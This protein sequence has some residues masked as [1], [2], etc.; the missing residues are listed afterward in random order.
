MGQLHSLSQGPISEK[1]WK[2]LIAQVPEMP[3]QEI[4]DQIKARLE[5]KNVGDWFGKITFT[6]AASVDDIGDKH[7]QFFVSWKLTTAPRAIDSGDPD[8]SHALLKIQ[9]IEIDLRDDLKKEVKPPDK[10]AVL[11]GYSSEGYLQPTTWFYCLPE[12]VEVL[13]K[14]ALDDAMRPFEDVKE[15]DFTKPPED[16]A[17]QDYLKELR[18]ALDESDDAH[19]D[20]DSLIPP[21]AR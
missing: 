21:S 2:F 11:H 10:L 18:G 1:L 9:S 19:P 4:L 3:P 14:K 5:E 8:L 17:F 20:G 7:P 12:E 15:I 6:R 16:S 13:K